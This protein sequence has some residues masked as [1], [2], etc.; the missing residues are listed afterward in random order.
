ML[1]TSY[2]IFTIDEETYDEMASV[3]PIVAAL[4]RDFDT[5]EDA[6]RAIK[7]FHMTGKSY[8]IKEVIL[9]Q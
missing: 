7:Y 6:L 5:K 1:K 3:L 4:R 8:T 9:C 2:R